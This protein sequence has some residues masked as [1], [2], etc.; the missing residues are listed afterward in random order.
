MLLAAVITPWMHQGGRQFATVAA[1]KDLPALLEWLGAACG[2]ASISRYYARS[3]LL[4]ALLILPLLLRR[5]H[6][7]RSSMGIGGLHAW[8]WDSWSNVMSQ[9]AIGCMISGGMLWG[10]G[11]MLELAGA[12]TPKVSHPGSGVLFS[13]VLLPVVSA[14]LIEEW[15]FRGLLLGL[16]LRYARPLV[17]CLGSSLL[18]AFL[19]FLNPPEGMCIT[20]P[21]Q[22]FAGIQLLGKI[23]RHFTDPLFFITD[24]AT[25]FVVGLILAW[26]RIRTGA[27]W[28]PIGLHAGWIMVF[29][30]YNLIYEGV[31]G[32]FLRPWGVGDSLRSG[33]LPLCTLGLTA[34]ICH[35]AL[36]RF[37][38]D[39]RS[40]SRAS[41]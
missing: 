10:L 28:F 33:I 21:S 40:V 2:R 8:K 12:Y 22:A 31:P 37:E 5:I 39:D 41:R 27:L 4:S 36:R 24:F 15:L 20:D 35:F 38:K 1:S 7:L 25:L 16:W 26:A 34:V 9:L 29:K 23:L 14:S 6:A 11:A 17:A 13:K 32:H 19:H 18:F 30:G 3:L